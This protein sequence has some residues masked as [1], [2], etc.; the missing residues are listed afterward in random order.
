MRI[1]PFLFLSLICLSVASA[2]SICGN[3][4]S[5]KWAEI[6][7]MNWDAETFLPMACEGLEF[8]ANNPIVGRLVV[9]QGRAFFEALVAAIK[10][11]EWLDS[12]ESPDTRI[13]LSVVYAPNDAKDVV[14]IGRDS[15]MTI[16]GKNVRYSGDLERL[17]RSAIPMSHGGQ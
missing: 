13:R 8:P 15:V 16:N 4:T 6:T 17:A 1:N 2:D 7:Y 14:C 3:G 9:L 11:L 10:G 5:V 12:S